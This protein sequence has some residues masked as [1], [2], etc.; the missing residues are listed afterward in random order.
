MSGACTG[1]RS[2]AGG[3][4]S[5]SSAT[6]YSGFTCKSSYCKSGS[7]CLSCASSCSSGSDTIASGKCYTGTSSYRNCSSC[8]SKTCYTGQKIAYASCSAAGYKSSKTGY[9]GTAQVS[10]KGNPGGSCT[11][12]TCYSGGSKVCSATTYPYSSSIANATMSG[13][14][15]GYTGTS[16]GSCSGSST[17]RYSGFT[18]KSGYCKVTGRELTPLALDVLEPIT[19]DRCVKSYSS[20]TAAGYKSS[21]VRGQTCT[22]VTVYNTSCSALTCYS[23]RASSSSSS[24]SSSSGGSINGCALCC[25]SGKPY[26][27]NNQCYSYCPAGGN[28]Q[29]PMCALRDDEFIPDAS[30]PGGA[31]YSTCACGGTHTARGYTGAHACTVN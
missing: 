27:Y 7:S 22:S 30:C 3:S 26:C 6:Y 23:C 24:S 4:C 14:C 20:C 11:T 31:Q 5:G 28:L 18:C 12:L 8:G 2:T 15:T 16:A 10:I 13:A 1:Y 17:T 9:C 29:C 21:K 25:T 19:V